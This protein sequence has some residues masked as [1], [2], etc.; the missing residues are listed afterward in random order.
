MALELYLYMGTKMSNK[1][2][3]SMFVQTS[4]LIHDLAV[5]STTMLLIPLQLFLMR[6]DCLLVLVVSK[7]ASQN[8]TTSNRSKDVNVIWVLHVELIKF[9][10]RPFH[11]LLNVLLAS[12]LLCV[13]MLQMGH[14]SSAHLRTQPK[15]P[16]FPVH[17]ETC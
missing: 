1:W 3:P 17:Q 14:L 9:W 13:L 7:V 8:G 10:W 4:L 2:K 11:P 5:E 12:L 6:L 16:E 15:L